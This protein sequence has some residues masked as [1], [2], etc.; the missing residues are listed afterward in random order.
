[1]HPELTD[2]TAPSRLTGDDW[3]A[4]ERTN[5]NE[6]VDGRVVVVPPEV[7]ANAFAGSQLI[8]RFVNAAGGAYRVLGPTQVDTTA[9]DQQYPTYRVTDLTV[10]RAGADL[11]GRTVAVSDILL[12]V[13]VVSDSSV[14]TD[15]VDKRAEYARVAIPQYL[16]VD[17]RPGRPRLLLL[18]LTDDEADDASTS[19]RPR[20][21]VVE[22]GAVVTVAVA[23]VSIR[24]DIA[25][26]CP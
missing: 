3:W 25:D 17:V 21:R 7:P 24:V 12:V 1:M 14:R 26:L 6:L 22:Q 15:L 19:D 4:I 5:A 20:Y 23:G 18:A 13:E 9:P 8:V 11:R 2:R 10:L 16:I